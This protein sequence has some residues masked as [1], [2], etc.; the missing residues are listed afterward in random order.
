MHLLAVEQGS[1][2]V[3]MF[4]VLL[5]YDLLDNF[6][7]LAI[8]VIIFDVRVHFPVLRPMNSLMISPAASSFILLMINLPYLL[9]HRIPFN[10][11]S[12]VLSWN[13]LFSG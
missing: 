3:I 10:F 13:L 6:S 8:F 5:D 4:D 7:Y 11:T 12:F 1:F 9:Y 2:V